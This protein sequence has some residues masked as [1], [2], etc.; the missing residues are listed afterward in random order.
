MRCGGNRKT[1]RQRKCAQGER[2]KN[3]WRRGKRGEGG[4]AGINSQ[5]IK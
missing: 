1:I 4:K 5:L 3:Q 2:E